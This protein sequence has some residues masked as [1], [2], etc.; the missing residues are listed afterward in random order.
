MSDEGAELNVLVAEIEVIW[1][2]RSVGAEPM[3]SAVIAR[4][5]RD[6]RIQVSPTLPPGAEK[7]VRA[8]AADLGDG[9]FSSL[10]DRLHSALV[11]V[12]G[13][14]SW[15]VSLCYDCSRPVGIAAPA[16]VRLISTRGTDAYRLR[17]AADWGAKADWERLLDNGFP[18]AAATDG[19]QVLAVCETARWSVK[20]AEAGVWT[21]PGMRGRGLAASVVAAWATQCAQRVPRLYYSTSMDNLSSQRV[22]ERLGLPRIGELWSLT[23]D[24][25]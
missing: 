3:P 22:A 2:S 13:P 23:P 9:P 8:A 1:G 7:A 4:A 21:M 6:W 25:G 12:G 16:G 18:W 15:E 20:G 11:P 10:L 19:D 14:H 17:I 5:G 24:L